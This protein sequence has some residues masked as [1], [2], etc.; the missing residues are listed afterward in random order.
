MV[1]ITFKSS[2]LHLRVLG[3]NDKYNDTANFLNIIVQVPQ[4]QKEI[5]ITEG[6]CI[7]KLFANQLCPTSN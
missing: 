4:K 2:Q 6:T 3:N 7:P 5:F 1:N